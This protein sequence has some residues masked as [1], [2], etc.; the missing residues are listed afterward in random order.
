MKMEDSAPPAAATVIL[1][2]QHDGE[3][4]AYLLKR[5]LK[6]RFMAGNYV[7]PGGMVDAEDRQFKLWQPHVDLDLTGLSQ[8]LGGKLTA[9]Q[10][11]AYGVA[12]IRETLEE[13]GVFLAFKRGEN[14][15]SPE[16]IF[17]LRLSGD[18]KQGW[19][20]KAV[21]SQGW[22]LKLSALM[23]W[24]HW[25]TPVL[26]KRRYDTRFFLAALPSGQHCQPDAKETIHGLWISPRAGLAGNLAG[27]I[28]LSPPTL[29][30]LHQ[31]L[32]YSHLNDLENEAKNR[33]WGEAFL[34][35]LIPMGKGALIIEPWDP[36][37]NQKE[38]SINPLDLPQRVLPLEESF[39]RIWYHNGIWRPVAC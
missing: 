31:L 7:F 22:T 20:L 6:S 26:M 38:V 12:A 15:T 1:A 30:T 27:E 35:R 3:L 19:F 8:H 28:P 16:Q 9:A 4:Q 5:S 36:Q 2:R 10:A 17:K 14:V 29:I 24:S 21:A 39:S 33:Q 13:A 37:Y 25:I 23:R 18:L 32:K 11:L 34:P